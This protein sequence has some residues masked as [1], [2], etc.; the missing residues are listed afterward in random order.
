[1]MSKSSLPHIFIIFFNW[2]L[3]FIP[4]A[5]VLSFIDLLGCLCSYLLD[6]LRIPIVLRKMGLRG[7]MKTNF[8]DGGILQIK[9]SIEQLGSIPRKGQFLG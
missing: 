8:P 3:A 5:V 1:M 4:C 2:K 7:I 6:Q 9:G